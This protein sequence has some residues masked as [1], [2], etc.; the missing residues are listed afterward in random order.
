MPASGRV[1]QAGAVTA[2]AEPVRG[3]LVRFARAPLTRR[4]WIELLYVVVTVPLSVAGLVLQVALLAVGALLSITFIG[5][6]VLGFAVLVGRGLG[7]LHRRLARRLLGLSIVAPTGS[8]TGWRLIPPAMREARGWRA[9]AYVV[10]KGPLA[11][12]LFAVAVLLR[13]YALD[14]VSR[15]VGW[16]LL[17]G[18]K[19]PVTL[20][21]DF[22]IGSWPS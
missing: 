11:A 13:W 8:A 16:V 20:V 2:A 10:V 4:S 12:V 6:P 9:I 22:G 19:D 3:A 14:L 5:L 17:P 1:R 7:E 15:V 21:G 18:N